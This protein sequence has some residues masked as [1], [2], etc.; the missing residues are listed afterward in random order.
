MEDSTG[1][2]SAENVEKSE[3]GVAS[4]AAIYPPSGSTCF[5]F[6]Q[7]SL[8]LL[9]KPML[10]FLFQTVVYLGKKVGSIWV[11]VPCIGEI[12]SCTYDDLCSIL[13][14]IPECP[15]P[16]TSNGVPCQC[17]FKKVG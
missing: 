9:S 16:F 1:N 7:M 3:L 15:D 5:F 14:M 4:Y 6:I 2:C 17:P 12:G 11:K 10:A 13:S 8:F